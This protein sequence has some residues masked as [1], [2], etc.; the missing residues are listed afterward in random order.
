VIEIAAT[1][2]A[3]E[4]DHPAPPLRVMR[5]RGERM[6][7]LTG[8]SRIIIAT[9]S[10]ETVLYPAGGAKAVATFNEIIERYDPDLILSERGDSVLFPALLQVA[11][12]E[13]LQLLLDRDRVITER[14]IETE[15]RTYFSY[16]N[17]IYKPPSYPLRGR[18]H[19]DRES[20]F[21]HGET[22]LEGL[23]EISRL[24]RLHVQRTARRSPG[25]L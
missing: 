13:K 15:G 5:M 8:A 9:G 25:T 19:I 24:S 20:S 11:K 21:A 2:S 1:D 14:K 23:L 7:P 6:R 18:W 16:G 17:I 22:W 3:W 12:S 4:I 10:D